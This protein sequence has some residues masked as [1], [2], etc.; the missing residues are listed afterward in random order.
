M[1]HHSRLFVIYQNP[2][3]ACSPSPGLVYLRLRARETDIARLPTIAAT[4]SFN[5][6]GLNSPP[7]AA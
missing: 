6:F 5:L 4:S 2:N 3:P 7:L 1:F